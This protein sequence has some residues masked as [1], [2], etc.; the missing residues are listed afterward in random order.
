MKKQHKSHTRPWCSNAF[1]LLIYFLHVYQPNTPFPKNKFKIN[2]RVVFSNKFQNLEKKKKKKRIDDSNSSGGGE[3]KQFFFHICPSTSNQLS[4]A[5]AARDGGAAAAVRV[6]LG[7]G[8]AVVVGL[9]AARAGDVVP[10]QCAVANV[11][12]ARLQ[13]ASVGLRIHP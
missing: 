12:P 4:L 9:A 7:S 5:P 13:D 10:L 6:G 8:A 1:Q 2:N 3:E 11:P